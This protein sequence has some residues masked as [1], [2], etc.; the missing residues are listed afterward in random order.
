MLTIYGLH[1]FYY[2]AIQF[3]AK[4][5]LEHIAFRVFTLLLIVVDVIVVI[6]DLANAGNKET[7]EILAVV[8][9]TYFLL[10]IFV[11]IFAKG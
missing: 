1:T 5:V 10:E 7:I 8:I 4:S 2:R 6:L 9:C 11:R 3:Q